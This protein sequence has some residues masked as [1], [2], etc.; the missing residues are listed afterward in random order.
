[1]SI[2]RKAYGENC[3]YVRKMCGGGANVS[4]YEI[5]NTITNAYKELLDKQNSAN[6]EQIR[7]EEET[8]QTKKEITKKKSSLKSP[9]Q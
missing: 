9:K 3:D 4:I 6:A 2:D 1:M 7:K 8:C 5:V